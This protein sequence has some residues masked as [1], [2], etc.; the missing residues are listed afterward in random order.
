MFQLVQIITTK[1]KKKKKIDNL[2]VRKLRTIFTD[3]KK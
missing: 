2:D 3:L 1:K